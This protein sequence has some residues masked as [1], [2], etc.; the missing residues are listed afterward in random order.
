MQ[1]KAGDSYAKESPKNYRTEAK[2]CFNYEGQPSDTLV[3]H[4][5]CPAKSVWAIQQ[6]FPTPVGPKFEF[7]QYRQMNQEPTETPKMVLNNG[8]ESAKAVPQQVQL[9]AGMFT[10]H[11]DL[12]LRTKLKRE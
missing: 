12:Q 6:S 8:L 5:N 3:G 9:R 11:S 1:E 4:G 7:S 2:G 10:V